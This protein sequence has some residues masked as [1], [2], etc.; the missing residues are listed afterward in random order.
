MSSLKMP[1]KAPLLTRFTATSGATLPMNIVRASRFSFVSS[2]G[3]YFVFLFTD[4]LGLSFW[5]VSWINAGGWSSSELSEPGTFV[6]TRFE[7]SESSALEVLGGELGGEAILTRFFLFFFSFRGEE[8]DGEATSGDEGLER[9]LSGSSACAS[10]RR[11]FFS[12]TGWS[13][14]VGSGRSSAV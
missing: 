8:T 3:A 12:T 14:E 4:P 5:R 2:G 7:L 13:L 1:V 10:D 9:F 6:E 11:F